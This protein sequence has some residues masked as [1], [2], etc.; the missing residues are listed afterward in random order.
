M[1]RNMLFITHEYQLDPYPFTPASMCIHAD[2]VEMN[3]Y[4]DTDGTSQ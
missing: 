1:V 4:A 2:H 3:Y